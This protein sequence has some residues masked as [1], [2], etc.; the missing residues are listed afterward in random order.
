V[1]RKRGA[2]Q[3][4]YNDYVT[5]NPPTAV[6]ARVRFVVLE[7]G[8]VGDIDP[9]VTP[10]DRELDECIVRVFRSIT[11]PRPQGGPARVFYPIRFSM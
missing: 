4:C 2:F 11:F 10:P 6:E 8:T 9:S 1:S 5:R 7:D 3:L